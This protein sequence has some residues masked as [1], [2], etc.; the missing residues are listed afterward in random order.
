MVIWNIDDLLNTLTWFLLSCGWLG[1]ND[2]LASLRAPPLFCRKWSRNTRF[3]DWSLI[4][5]YLTHSSIHLIH[6]IT[7]CKAS[8]QIHS[9]TLTVVMS[10]RGAK[11]KLST[12]LF[13]SL[14]HSYSTRTNCPGRYGG[15]SL[16]G[17][18]FQ[19]HKILPACLLRRVHSFLDRTLLNERDTNPIKAKQNL[20]AL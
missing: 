15:V 4:S 2:A 14:C 20:A 1:S 16:R 9:K 6:T 5:S 7:M 11:T 3:L 10:C 18:L 12:Q 8:Q 17:N 19:N 13:L